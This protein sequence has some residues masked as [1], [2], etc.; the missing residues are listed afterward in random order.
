MRTR[1]SDGV[2]VAA[3]VLL[4]LC[5]GAVSG[6]GGAVVGFVVGANPPTATT[7]AGVTGVTPDPVRPTMTRDE[8]RKA[9]VGKT[10]DEVI[11]TVGRPDRTDDLGGIA[12]YYRD[13][14]RD[15]VSLKTDSSAQVVFENGRVVRVNY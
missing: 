12:W 4:T 10:P 2:P 7:P 15:P 11:A 5:I 1:E 9:V 3:V 6:L 13:R 14:T 8:F